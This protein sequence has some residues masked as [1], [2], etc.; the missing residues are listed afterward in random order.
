MGV[1]KKKEMQVTALTICHQDLETL[2]FLADVEGKNLASLLLYCVQL[3]DGVSQIHY[4]KQIVPLLEKADK[5]GACDPIIRSCLDILAGIYL[6]LSVKNP[7]KKVLASSLNG[8]PEFFLTEA[9]Q[10]FTSRLQEELNTTDLYSYRKVIDNISSCME[11][12]D[13]GRAGVNNLLKNV[14]HFLQK[15]L[16][17]I[18]EENRKFAG[19]RIVQTQLMND[20]LVG[21]RVSV[22]LVQKIQDIQRIHLK[23]SSSPTW[24]SMC[25]LLSIFTKFLSDDD[26]LQTIQS[27]SGLA[28]ILFIKAMFHPP[29]KIPDLISSLLLRSVD[30][31]SIPDWFLNCCRSLCCTDVSQSTLLFLCQGTLTMLD[32]QNGSMDL[33]GEALLLNIVHILFTLSSQIKEST[34]ELF[35]SR[36]LASWTNSAIHVLK[37]SSPSLKNSLNGK[38]SVVGRLLE[39]VYT[40]WE[41]PLDALRHQTKIIFR[42]ILQMHQ[43]T[44]EK[45]NS[46]V[47]GLAADHFICDLT[48]GLLRL[49]WHVKGK[50]TCLGCLVDY[51]GIGHI[52]ALA[53]TI[54]SQILEVMGDQS[55]VPYASDLLETMFRSH[56]NHL[57]SQALDST[58]IDEWH[59][60]WVSPLLFI[61]CEGNLDQ[62][63]YVIDY[64]LPKLLNCSPESLSYMVKILQTSA[65]AKTGSYNSRGALGALMACLRTARAH[66]HLQSATDTWRNLVSSA[67]IKQGL[68]HQHCQVRIDTLGLLCESN[69]STEI[70]S[71]EEMQW[72]QFFITYNL[73]SQS[74]GVR[75]QICSLLK[76]LFCRIQESSQVLYKQ[77]QSRS[78]H[79][80]ENELTKQHPSVSLQQ[81]KNFMSSICSHLFEALFPGS[82]YPTRFSALTILGSIAE[83]FPVTEGQ[84][85]AVYQLSHDIDVGRFQTLMECF[86]ST[87]EE[88][89]ILAFDLLMKLPKTVVQF[90]DSEKLQG[91]F[92]AALELSSSTKPYD[93]VTASYLLNFLIW[94]DVLPSSLFDSLKTQQTACEDG[95]KSAIVVERN[96][97]MVI[98]CLL[99]NLEEEVSQAEN[100]LLQ[101]A[102]SFPLYG[103]VHCV[104]GAL[105]RLSLNNLQLVSEW[106]PV[107]EKLL[108]MSYRLSAVVSPVIQS[109]SPEGLIPMDTDSES[110]SRL[111]TILNEIQPRDTNDYFTQ[112]KILKE[113]DSFDLED[114]NVSVQN[115][116]ASAEVK[117]KERKTCDV[118]AQMVLVCCWRSMK[119]V[120]LLLGTLCQLLPMQSVPESSNGLLTE[121]QVKEIGD[122]FKQHLL[123]SRHR[124][125]FELAYT[126]FVKL[127]EILNRCPNVSLQ[128]LPEQWLW[129]VL[130]EIKCSDP[131]SKLCATRRSA[132]IPFYIQA[133]LASEPKKGKMDLLKITMKELIS[134]AGPTD[135]SQST[136]PQVHALNILR[137]L[138]RDTRLGENIIPYVA[139]G[140]KAAILGFTSPVWAVRNSSTLLFSTLITRI[141]GV[142]RGKDEL[143]KKNRMTGSEFFSRF[144][145]LYPFLLQQLEAVANTVD[146]D[147]GELNRHPSMFLLLL[148]LGR[149]YPSPMDGTYSALSMAPFIPFIMSGIFCS[150]SQRV[151]LKCSLTRSSIR[152]GR[153][154][155]YRSREMAARALVPFVMV[156]EI[157]TTIRTLLA[158]LP[159]CTDQRFRQNHIHGTL[160]QVFH[161]LQAFTDSKYRLNTYFQQELADVAVCTRAKLWLAERQNPCL[162]T[163]AVYIDILFLLTR[164]LDKPTKGNQPAVECLGFWE[165]VRR[166]ISGSELITGFTYTFTVP[167]LPQYLQ[168]LTKLAITTAAVAAQA[169]EQAGN[170]P[171]SFSQLLESSFPEVRLLTLEALLERFSTAAL[172]LGEKGLPPLQR[173]M[174]ETFLMLAVKENHPECFCK[175]LKILHCMDP[176]EWLSH[177][178][179]C[180][181]LT[182]K[183]FL[184]WTMDIASNERS[185]VQSV[186]LRL[187]S[188][189]IAHHL[190]MCEETRDSVAPTLKQWVQLVVSSCGEHLPTESRLAAAEALT[191]TTPFLLTS[192][193][194]VLGLQD[195]LALWRCVLTLLQS[196][197]QAV[198][199]AA[200][201]TVVTAMS[202]ENTCRSTE[203]AFCQVDASIALTLALAVLCDLLQQ[204]DQLAL[205]LPVL[206]G[207]LLGEDDDFVVHLENTHQVE[208]Y[209]FEKA[210]I[211]FWAETLI[212]VKYLHE[213]LLRLLSTSSRRPLSPESLR[214]LRRTAS[215]QGHLLSQLF[216]ELPP[217]AEFLKTV[218]FT[219]LRIQEERTLACLQLLAFLEGKERED[220]PVLRASDSPAEAN[221]FTLAKTETAH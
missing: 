16:I 162:V 76:K 146:S 121:E 198:R 103:R 130:E 179:R 6:S 177:M 88:V 153:S 185:E 38:S 156:D 186:A 217:A 126:G 118:T 10:S 84:V 32:W 44:K 49:E 57:K 171:I 100:S 20:L 102:A 135:D 80:P 161:L 74:P 189:V 174:G 50:Y 56:K 7:L 51:I 25:G 172:G 107:I 129:N 63:S 26:L 193:H 188:R 138:F 155:D 29:E 173:N 72:I 55:L 43:L 144:P 39:Y 67:R 97:L 24:Q 79:E 95:D 154:P 194:P 91:L 33:S 168:S 52:L 17:E 54:P 151:A 113:H 204:W 199:D 3:T 94:Q 37:S 64:Y 65:D 8:L 149:L 211:N 46:E 92:Q 134:L 157:P 36:I 48:E 200:T 15:S 71:T 141:F 191:S 45:S 105:Q 19:N 70:V 207:W 75:Q 31:T 85:Q 11:N 216:R 125:A 176:S 175:I 218:E 5:N 131:S 1:K 41:H 73:N 90:Q 62:K 158:K 210:E 202:Q 219:R 205:G 197:E 120:A 190:Q 180:I 81:Y 196:E 159:N 139:D 42:N 104:T 203:F 132:G 122:Y 165:D 111:Q 150:D 109:S 209:L 143:S 53:K 21:T 93:C 87:F 128:K 152:C 133:L 117:G 182:P 142:K 115:I 58:W 69:R 77:E 35:L 61:L 119:E 112:A 98:K 106:R 220:T 13:L 4:V 47:S 170:I 14:L 123:Q 208:D 184:I 114:L 89:K 187:A 116:G 110:A 60:T 59:E 127:T 30:C 160:L 136:V 181:H 108:L 124:G 86:T 40:H 78:K 145:E 212:F 22:M 166:I 178:Q 18:S 27:T 148:V 23:T 215:E 140:A 214:H 169:G 68:I 206:L 34:L 192:P 137:A 82:S 99:E 147:T 213:H 101:A 195:T 201:G 163:R 164:C 221:Q 83:V 2:R 12:F 167:G 28:V 96:T 183:E 9:I 66:G